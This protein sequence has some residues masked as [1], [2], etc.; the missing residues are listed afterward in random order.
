MYAIIRSGG[1]Q[2]RV[3]ENTVI[4]VDKIPAQPGEAFTTEEVLLVSRDGEVTIGRPYV[5]KARVIGT[6]LEHVKGEK[7][8]GLKFKPK[9]NY[10]KRYGH[11]QMF[12]RI[13]IDRIEA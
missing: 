8:E 11:R 3:E 4:D 7:I 10:L 2:Y 1:K 9:K 6:V 12:S 13:R 5:E